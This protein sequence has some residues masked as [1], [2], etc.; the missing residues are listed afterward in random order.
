MSAKYDELTPFVCRAT[1]IA[2]GEASKGDG[3]GERLLFVG[4]CSATGDEPLSPKNDASLL[5]PG[6]LGVFVMTAGSLD[7]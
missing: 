6:D 7:S 3:P 2:L 5:G 4:D 1:S